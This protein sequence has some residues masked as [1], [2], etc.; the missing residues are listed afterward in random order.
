MNMTKFL[1][2]VGGTAFVTLPAIAA[3]NVLTLGGLAEQGAL[4]YGKTSPDAK[5]MVGVDEVPVAPDG[6]FVFGISR[7]APDTLEIV[8]VNAEGVEIK[9]TLNIKPVAWDIQK[10]NNP[11]T[12][13]GKPQA[14][15]MTAIIK[16]SD[17]I[18]AARDVVTKDTFPVCFTAPLET[19]T[20]S[21]AFGNQ[22][23]LNGVPKQYHGGVDLQAAMGTPVKA[24]ADGTITHINTNSYYNGKLIIID[25]GYGISSSYAHLSKIDTEIGKKVKR[26]EKIGE[27]GST[28]RSTEPHLHFG[29]HYMMTPLDPIKAISI[30]KKN[31]EEEI[32]TD[33]NS[34]DNEKVNDEDNNNSNEGND[35]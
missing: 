33:N 10:I 8:S 19:M 21:G 16:D 12:R 31:C 22:R 32:M 35:K 1:L 2:T 9:R 5:V 6:Q 27:V 34:N 26:G 30:T 15:D 20:V 7:D 14:V 29:L 17:A 11:P 25:H 13:M 18:K 4:F 3:F 28:G 23:I 24:T